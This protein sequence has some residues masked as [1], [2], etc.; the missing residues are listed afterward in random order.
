M[1]E[2][3]RAIV[4]GLNAA[5]FKKDL[6]LIGFDAA[7]PLHLL[8]WLNDIFTHISPEQ[9]RRVRDEDPEDMIVRMLALLRALKYKPPQGAKAN[10]RQGLIA[11][12]P[13]VVY[14]VMRWALSNLASLK[15]RAYLARF[16]VRVEVPPEFLQDMQVND[17]HEL[18]L[19]AIEEF[20]EVHKQLEGTKSGGLSAAEIKKDIANMEEEKEQLRRRIDRLKRKSEGIGQYNKMLAACRELRLERE[21]EATLAEQHIDQRNQLLNVEDKVQKVQQQLKEAQASTVTTGIEGLFS[22]VEQEIKMNQY[23]CTEKLPTAISEKEKI[24][25]ELAHVI[26]QPAM[27]QSD[28]DDLQRQIQGLR[29]EINALVEKRMLSNSPAEDKIATFKQQAAIIAG[30]KSSVA[31]KLQDV[32]DELEA[33]RVELGRKREERQESGPKMLKPEEFKRYVTK[34][35]V[36][37]NDYKAKKSELAELRAEYL[38]LVRTD[39]VLRDLESKTQGQLEG[40]EA[41]QGVAGAAAI[42]DDLE[43]VSTLKSEVDEQKGRTLQDISQMVEELNAVIESKKT[44]LAPL[45]K[46]FRAV[47]EK[48]QELE[49]VYN[50]KKAAYENTSAGLESNRSRLDAD[51]RVLREEV[52]AEESR[53]HYLSAMIS[54][55]QG[56]RQRAVEEMQ[57]YAGG[58]GGGKGKSLRD[59]YSKRIQEQE[60]LGKT[61]REKQ[62]VVKES[63]EPNMRQQDLW[64]DMQALFEGKLSCRGAAD[65]MAPAMEEEDRLVL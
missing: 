2:D 32:Q 7:E 13:E 52:S 58:A 47:R 26:D 23:L 51:V 37:S 49:S 22:R 34:L 17:A 18:Y 54:T 57:S 41:A 5:P 20:K 53:Y 1:A 43:K 44:S 14:P 48:A 21:R 3:A 10:F 65:S 24:V 11:A 62:K 29:G 8:Q 64:R 30:K 15:K 12:S 28:L 40:L 45:I 31:E 61:L 55:L 9:E 25:S 46:E 36:K 19:A 60:N 4:D 63:H 35:R 16:L 39:E 27:G 38:L 33:A 42:Q 56:Q 50:E 59:I 6:T